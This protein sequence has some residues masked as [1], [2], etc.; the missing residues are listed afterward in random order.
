MIEQMAIAK[1]LAGFNGLGRS[2]TPT[3]LFKT[4]FYLQLS[5]HC[6][7]M[8]KKMRNAKLFSQGTS[9]VA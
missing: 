3:F 6:S 9:P 1:A 2:M 7:K 5:P 8:N 4:R